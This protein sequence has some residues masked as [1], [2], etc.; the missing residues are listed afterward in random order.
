MIFEKWH[1]FE[2]SKTVKTVFFH[3]CEK[4]LLFFLNQ[5]GDVIYYNEV[6]P[7]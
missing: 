2:K 3:S 1:Y 7:N 5:L 6:K 4:K